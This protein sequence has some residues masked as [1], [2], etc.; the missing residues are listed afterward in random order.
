MERKQ[1]V[2]TFGCRLNSYESQIIKN[3]LALSNYDNVIVFNTCAVTKEAE[4]QAMQSIRKAKRENPDSQIIV[5]GC[6]AQTNPELFANM[7]EIDKILG[8]E[9]KLHPENYLFTGDRVL[10]NDIMSVTETAEHLISHFDGRSRAFIQVQNGCNHRCT[11]CIIP[12]GR[13]N[14]RSVP[15]GAISNQISKLVQDGFKEIVLTGV[16]VTSYGPD[17]PGSPSFAQMIRRVL[18]AN[19]S[20]TRLRLSSIDVAEIDEE[21]FDL[22]ASEKRIMPHLHI[23]L[24]AG[25]NMILKRM[26]RRH[27]REQVI[28]F[29][30]N[31]R[32][33]RHDMAFGADIIAGFPTETEE[34]FEN[35]RLL[36][37][38][39]KLQYLHIFPYSSRE[40][41]PAARMPQIEKKIRQM[42]AK[43]LREEGE[44]ELLK[45][46]ESNI[47]KT[48]EILVENG[49]KGHSENFIPV[50][51]DVSLEQ[52]QL[53][54][55]RL[56]SIIDKDSMLAKVNI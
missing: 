33:A 23:S 9:E 49:N 3:N 1:E 48:V 46:Y 25:D 54:K 29:C 41:T 42:R 16:D 8:N 44:K 11:F 56:V 38:E 10:V 39:A 18:A 13:G 17:L 40:G 45:F 32:K 2:V 7:P 12:Y 21:L 50:K 15:I 4:R 19:P 5:T 27:N 43:I 24:Q 37:S 35:T 47:G 31:M 55:A 36:I 6:A 14:S 53:V 52:G 28:E 22:I 20:L 34:M 51:M 30:N 26:K